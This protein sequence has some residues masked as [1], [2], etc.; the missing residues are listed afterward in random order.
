MTAIS[1]ILQA[2]AV[3]LLTDGAAFD[4][5]GKVVL[6]MTKVRIL[7]HLNA[8][9]AC[10]GPAASPS[11][12]ADTF[13]GF[14]TS[15]DDLRARAPAMV[16]HVISSSGA[17]FACV[18]GDAL[19][20]VVGGWSETHGPSAF[21]I[22]NHD[23][24]GVEPW[25]AVDMEGLCVTPGDPAILE[26]VRARLPVGVT[27]DTLD[28]VRDGLTILEAQREIGATTPKGLGVPGAAGFAQLTTI[29]S[30]VITT[31]ILR[32]WDDGGRSAPRRAN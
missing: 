13:N 28:P 19:D 2:S 3:H 29:T 5:E 8:V 32:R 12:V 18:H 24:Y 25:A 27:A 9:V 26:L 14:A 30:D 15:F 6:E 11:I 20:V 7:A 1:T 23:G 17:I 16:R 10:R 4:H 22:T 21:L 31:R